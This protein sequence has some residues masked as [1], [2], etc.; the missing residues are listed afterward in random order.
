MLTDTSP[1]ALLP[2]NDTRPAGLRT[3]DLGNNESTSR[4]MTR[5]GDGWLALTSVE[6]RTLKTERGA[7]AWLAR[8]GL[9]ADGSRV[10]S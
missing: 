3:T 5:C 7:I 8:R 1:A 4:G 10:A 9:R 2:A 6:S